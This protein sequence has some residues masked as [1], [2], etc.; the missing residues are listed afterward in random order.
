MAGDALPPLV[1]GPPAPT[2]A[3]SPR[4]SAQPRT[5][6][7]H[8]TPPA[9]RDHDRLGPGRRRRPSGTAAASRARRPIS[10]ATRLGVEQPRHREVELH[11]AAAD[12]DRRGE[13]GVGDRHPAAVGRRR[14]AAPAGGGRG[15]SAASTTK[16]ASAARARG[17][18]LGSHLVGQGDVGD[19]RVGERAFERRA[20]DC[21]TQ[22][23]QHRGGVA[24]AADR[25]VQRGGGRAGT[26]AGGP[27]RRVNGPGR[28]RPRHG[29]PAARRATVVD[30]ARSPGGRGSGEAAPAR[31][32]RR[33]RP[34]AGRRPRARDGGSE[35]S[36]AGR[37]TEAEPGGTA[38]ELGGGEG[39]A[40]VRVAG[41][42]AGREP[43]LALLAR[44]VRPR[45][46][47]DPAAERGSGGGRRRSWRRRRGRRRCRRR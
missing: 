33:R 22:A 47:V 25:Q 15:R 7:D 29:A 17:D 6:P 4:R 32:R 34:A 8:G 42:V 1:A 43:A 23:A 14:G 35:R 38:S 16:P 19:E 44:A 3:R 26:S 40:G 2:G 21:V 9:G 46:G 28:R 11:A 30:R 18:A 13:G 10:K 39:V 24:A 12:H 45:L 36:Q 27:S 5:T 20:E 31:G 41:A 37:R